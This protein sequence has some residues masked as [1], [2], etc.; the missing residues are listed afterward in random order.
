[1]HCGSP[2]TGKGTEELSWERKNNWD[3]IL[4]DTF[5]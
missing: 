1:M 5:N 4:F 2:V 3:K